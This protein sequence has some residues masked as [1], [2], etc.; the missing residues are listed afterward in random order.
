MGNCSWLCK[1]GLW[2]T[3]QF[4]SH[5]L[6]RWTRRWSCPPLSMAGLLPPDLIRGQW[7]HFPNTQ[8]APDLVCP[9]HAERSQL[10][11]HAAGVDGKHNP[12][13]T[14]TNVLLAFLVTN[15]L[16][17]FPKVLLNS[18]QLIVTQ[19]FLNGCSN[20][21]NCHMIP[22]GVCVHVCVRVCARVRVCV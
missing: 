1:V 19:G 15:K 18:Q 4:Q 14:R 21:S 9:G 12:S 6:W 22:R 10:T 11:H 5:L 16:L 13:H 7:V 20:D 17:T 8:C 3:F 2:S